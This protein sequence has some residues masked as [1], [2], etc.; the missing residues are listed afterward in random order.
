MTSVLTTTS[1]TRMGIRYVQSKMAAVADMIGLGCDSDA[2]SRR[3]VFLSTDELIVSQVQWLDHMLD[4]TANALAKMNQVEFN[5]DAR[6]RKMRE[7]GEMDLHG[8]SFDSPLARARADQP[9]DDV[10]GACGLASVVC[11]CGEEEC[12]VGNEETGKRKRVAPEAAGEGGAK[13]RRGDGVDLKEN[14]ISGPRADE[15]DEEE[16]KGRKYTDMIIS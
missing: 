4:W 3:Q 5:R 11:V 13:H 16:E 14:A 15:I 10:C 2:A 7:N 1:H 12:N 6:Q 9:Y 8:S